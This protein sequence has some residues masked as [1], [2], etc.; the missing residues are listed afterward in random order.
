MNAVDGP[1]SIGR[2]SDAFE[3]FYREHL[4]SIQRFIARRVD[5]PE[6]AADLTAEVFMAAIK[7]SAT[8]RGDAVPL[9]W[10]YGIARNVVSG[11]HR[12]RARAIRAVQR[13]DTRELLDDDATGR[14]LDRI[15][16]QQQA[17]CLYQSLAGL[18]GRQRAIVELVAVDGMTLTEAAN[19]LGITPGNARVRYH[20]A[21]RRLAQDLNHPLT[22]LHEVTS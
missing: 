20:R 22:D 19:A 21:R 14:I 6:D 7:A 17:R 2:D 8:Y 11:H 5:D 15:E 4:E 18:P 16:S 10:L 13:I 9:A 1:A 3:S 12:S